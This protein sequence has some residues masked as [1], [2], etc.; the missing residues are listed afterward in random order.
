MM[1]TIRVDDWNARPKYNARWRNPLQVPYDVDKRKLKTLEFHATD[2]GLDLLNSSRITL[3]ECYMGW[4]RD[5]DNGLKV[6]QKLYRDC[7]LNEM[8]FRWIGL[9]EIIRHADDL[10][11]FGPGTIECRLE[12]G[13]SFGLPGNHIA[14]VH[15]V[16]GQ[17]VTDLLWPE[18][19]QFTEKTT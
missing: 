5:I 4:R 8:D 12:S 17:P 9:K 3:K 13:L 14:E 1:K 15:R 16:I 10:S 6:V 7:L 11:G 2:E 19:T 18:H